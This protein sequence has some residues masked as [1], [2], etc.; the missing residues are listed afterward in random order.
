M[1]IDQ[2]YAL[3]GLIKSRWEGISGGGA[4]EE[5]VPEFFAALRARRAASDARACC[6][7]RASAETGD[8]RAATLSPSPEFAVTGAAHSAF[9]ATPTMVFSADRHRPER[10]TRSS[11]SR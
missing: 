6:R 2:C 10:R 1:P 8:E 9:A 7:E 11:R 3:V 5:A 4:I